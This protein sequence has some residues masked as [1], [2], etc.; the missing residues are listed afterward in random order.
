MESTGTPMSTTSALCLAISTG[1]GTAAALIHLA[2]FSSLPKHT[3]AVKQITDKPHKF[4]G[5]LVAAGL[6]SGS[7]VFGQYCSIVDISDIAPLC[8]I[9]ERWVKRTVHIGRQTFGMGQNGS[10][11]NSVRFRQIADKINKII[12]PHTG[13][14][15]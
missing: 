15:G 7:S 4:G 5:C 3:L 2:D 6:P 12:R 8:H 11:F 9:G 13:S 10:S 14:A 1:N